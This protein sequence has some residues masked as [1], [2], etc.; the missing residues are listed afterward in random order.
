MTS[1]ASLVT[2]GPLALAAVTFGA[3]ERAETPGPA[4]PT[5][6][7]VLVFAAG[8][9]LY[10]VDAAGN[11]R[12][13]VAGDREDQWLASPS[14]SPDGTR[15]VY[16]CGFDICVASADGTGGRILAKVAQLSTPPGGGASNW[17]LGAQSV[18]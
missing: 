14:F 16:T 11:V 12:P 15:L 8:G 2:L 5:G 18:A 7:P 13:L 4:S 10:G 1:R 6:A 9:S 3:C 17:S